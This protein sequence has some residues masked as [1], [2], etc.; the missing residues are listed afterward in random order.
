MDR[1]LRAK[2]DAFIARR[3]AENPHRDPLILAAFL[4]AAIRAELSAT[5][6]ASAI[7]DEPILAALAAHVATIN[8]A[9]PDDPYTV[10][11]FVQ[12]TLRKAIRAG[13]GH[14]I[15]VSGGTNSTSPT[16]RG[17]AE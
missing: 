17:A 13:A 7:L 6:A 11:R 3:N 15:R 2:V 10:E 5:R 9:H 8:A 4:R 12:V 14:P 16:K 1:G